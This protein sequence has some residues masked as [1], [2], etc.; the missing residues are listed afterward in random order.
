MPRP[1]SVDLRE[2]VIGSVV[3]GASRREA[4]EQ[5]GISPSIVVI[6]MQR[7]DATGSI[8]AKPSGGSVSPLDEHAEFLLGLIADHPDFTLDE[9]RALMLKA[10]I[11][12][13]RT[14]LW[15]FYARHGITFKKKPC[16]RPSENAT[17]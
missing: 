6:W 14:A 15:R 8:D 12:G 5:F 2:R 17:M 3:G 11:R 4:A 13:S 9:L 10:K 16:T 1:Y 7:F